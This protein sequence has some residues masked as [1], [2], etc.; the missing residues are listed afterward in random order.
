M[1]ATTRALLPTL[2][3]Q[4]TLLRQA[5]LV[6]GGAA[7]TALAAQAR[8]PLY[9]VPVTLQ[10]L[11]VMLCGITMGTRL[12]LLSQLVYVAAGVCGLPVFTEGS[13]GPQQLV[14]PT[15]GYIVAFILSAGLLGWMADRGWDR[16]FLTSS[17]ALGIGSLLILSM[18]TAWLATGMH[19]GWA[20]AWAV[21][22]AP[23][24][25][26]EVLKA[27]AVMTAMPLAWRLV[28]KERGE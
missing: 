18:G 28:G 23:F 19:M 26:I 4:Q 21:G 3:P 17:V 16:K 10:T 25:A 1:S 6:L 27:V 2:V 24:V 13:F 22:F 20:K 11:A 15:G 5:A 9:P 7:L 12:G 14:G 8:I